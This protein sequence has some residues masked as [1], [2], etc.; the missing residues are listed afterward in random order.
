[1]RLTHRSSA[2]RR[3]GLDDETVALFAGDAH[4][5]AIADA[6]HATQRPARRASG[7]GSL[8]LAAAVA[9]VVVASLGAVY[10]AT[11]K[12]GVI[13]KAR[14]AFPRAELL[15]VT[16]TNDQRSLRVIDASTGASHPVRHVITEW[17]DA[18]R[19]VREVIDRVGSVTISQ[20]GAGARSRRS[21]FAEAAVDFASAYA[22]ALASGEIEQAAKGEARGRPIYWLRLTKPG[23]LR[24]VAIDA[25]SYKPRIAVYRNGSRSERFQITRVETIKSSE[26]AP[27]HTVVPTLPR[28]LIRSR[29]RLAGADAAGAA[30]LNITERAKIASPRW[31]RIRF[32]DGMVG[33]SVRGQ[34]RA[35]G[36]ATSV[37]AYE[38]PRPMSAFGW[39]SLRDRLARGGR[40]LIERQGGFTTA[41]FRV[42]GRAVRV[43]GAVAAGQMIKLVRPLVAR[44]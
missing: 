28:N 21:G 20:S 15:R 41:Y 9:L 4:A 22:G 11:S 39:T 31:E 5:L 43:T 16:L 8:A 3:D 1:M 34:M 42:E 2:E 36:G 33:A 24:E 32:A 37:F 6:I 30:L 35:N 13:E 23:A 10:A 19:N 40:I 7:R 27:P 12:A 17:Y 44:P 25:S 26:G 29:T 38:A 18:R 14:S